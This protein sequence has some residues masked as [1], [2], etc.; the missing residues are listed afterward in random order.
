MSQAMQRRKRRGAQ[1]WIGTLGKMK[2]GQM[3]G[4]SLAPLEI[5]AESPPSTHASLGDTPRKQ[6]ATSPRLASLRLQPC[7]WQPPAGFMQGR[8]RGAAPAGSKHTGR[9]ALPPARP[10]GG[11]PADG[12]LRAPARAARWRL[13][14]RSGRRRRHNAEGSARA[15]AQGRGLGAV[16]TCARGGAASASPSRGAHR[17]T[18]GHGP[19]GAPLCTLSQA[20]APPPGLGAPTRDPPGSL[21]VP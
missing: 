15:R 7:T 20:R 4:E 18:W 21:R 3:L 9:R 8:Q 11:A 10:R 16:R 2:T 13:T 17:V 1:S 5:G 14:W 6:L 19:M 12:P